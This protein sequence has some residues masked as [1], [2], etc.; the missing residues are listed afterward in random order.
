MNS[1][2]LFSLIIVLARPDPKSNDGYV[3]EIYF[4]NSDPSFE[5][6]FDNLDF[7]GSFFHQVFPEHPSESGFTV[8]YS[9]TVLKSEAGQGLP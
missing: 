1:C 7:F 6:R 4:P 9:G 3:R 2:C 8:F 5:I